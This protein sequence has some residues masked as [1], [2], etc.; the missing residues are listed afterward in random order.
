MVEQIYMHARL[1]DT[2]LFLN[3]LTPFP[4]QIS[5]ETTTNTVVHSNPI[6]E[7]FGN[8]RTLR[9]DNSSRFGKF[10]DVRFIPRSGR[11]TSASI[12]TYLLEKVRLISPAVGERNYHIFY[13][14]LAGLSQRDRK[15]FLLGN[16]R[17]QDFHMTAVSGTFDRRDGIDDRKTFKDLKTALTTIGFT[18]DAAQQLFGVCCAVLQC[19]NLTFTESVSGASQIDGTNPS[20]RHAVQ[21]LGVSTE[22]LNSALCCSAIEARGEILYKTLSRGQAAKA[23]EALMKA[24]YA[25]LFSKIVTRINRSIAVADRGGGDG[26]LTINGGTRGAS[27]LSIGVLDIFGFESFDTNSFE[28]LCINF[29]NEALQQQFNQFVFKEEQN[30][31]QSEGIDWSFI[32]FPDNQDIL[33]LIEKRHD[34][35]LSILDEQNIVPGATDVTFSRTVYEKCGNHPRFS[36]NSSQKILGIFCIEH[37]AGIVEYSTATFLEKNKDELPKETTLLLKSSSNPFIVSL[38]DVLS[39]KAN[40]SSPKGGDSGRQLRRANSSLVRE[41]VGSQFTG[42]LRELRRKIE[43]TTP[44]YI[45]CLKPNDLLVPGSFVPGII[46]DQLRCAGVLEAIRVSRVGFPQR[47]KHAD[48][49]RRYQILATEQMPKHRRYYG[50]RDLCELVVN[51]AAVLI[52]RTAGNKKNDAR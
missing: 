39:V 7:S 3:S 41:S 13:E 29:C 25:A 8:A 38:G 12:D 45:R 33:D 43:Q 32:S 44:H 2:W 52:R 48:F 9:N 23:L 18:A 10:I 6:L 50:E 26:G 1:G 36:A 24:T 22:A 16:C 14:L 5:N 11:L 49:L 4:Q 42:Q 21:L 30:E 35:I 15:D 40:A 31:Y 47:Y 51:Y 19:S 46:A 28:Q 20:L 17:A 37:Y 34:G 27:D